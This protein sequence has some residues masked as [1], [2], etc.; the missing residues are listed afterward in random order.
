MTK[1]WNFNTQAIH[2]AQTPDE[3]TRAVSQP[4]VPAV[5]YSF[6]TA[7]DAVSV[8][9]GE[10]EGVYYGRYGNPTTRRLEKKVAS[11]EGS[12]DAL[13]VSSGMAAISISLMNFL[14][15]GDHVVVTKDV[16]GG[17]HKFLSTIAP[18]YGIE[19][20]YVDCTNMDT[21]K[22]AIQENTKAIYIETPSNPSLTLI[23]I[24]AV[25]EISKAN[26]IPLIVDNTF[27][28]PYLQ[29]PLELGADVVVHSATKY[30]NGHGDVVAG[31]IC[32]KEDV[33]T[34]MRK[35]VMGDLGQNLNAWESFMILRGIK[36]LGIIKDRKSTR[37]NSSHVAI[38]YAVFC[39]KKKITII[40]AILSTLNLCHDI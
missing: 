30:L 33:I 18:R 31:V 23:D 32:A 22:N 37:L 39:L 6:D 17:T 13:G 14:D 4:I 3:E 2:N 10:T 19:Y 7:E 35:N 36:T 34:N 27:M 24:K 12:E 11:L 25:S 38:S 1:N 28:T 29:R 26:N 15:S 20:D 40:S 16:Y 21:I 9:N 8:V 5:A